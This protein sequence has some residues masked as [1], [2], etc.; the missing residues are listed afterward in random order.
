VVPD[1]DARQ[2]V[3]TRCAITPAAG[4]DCPAASIVRTTVGVNAAVRPYLDEFPLPN[5]GSPNVV[6]NLA[7]YSFGF[8]Q[9]VR[10]HFLQGRVDYNRS[11]RAQM[12]ARYTFDDADQV[13][14]TDFPQFP[15]VS[16]AQSVFQRVPPDAFTHYAQHVPLQLQP[17]SHR[18]ER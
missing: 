11:D 10:Q 16:I 12:F 6:G 14:P 8:Q 18:A 4:Q 13:L 5:L 9:Q 2:G 1:L 3:V 7:A 17:H 15:R